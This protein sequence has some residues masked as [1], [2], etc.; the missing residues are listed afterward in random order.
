MIAESFQSKFLAAFGCERVYDRDST[1]EFLLHSLLR[2]VG[3]DEDWLAFVDVLRTYGAF[4][5]FAFAPAKNKIKLMICPTAQTLL[6]CLSKSLD[7][8]IC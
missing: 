1:L 2:L 3:E 6:T 8:P 4:V 5:R 7:A